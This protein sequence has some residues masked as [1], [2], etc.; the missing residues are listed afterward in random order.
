MATNPNKIKKQLPETTT[1]PNKLKRGN[2]Q[3]HNNGTVLNET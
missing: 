2:T 3:N 1:I